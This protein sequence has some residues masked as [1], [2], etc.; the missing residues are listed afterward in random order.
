MHFQA[1]LGFWQNLIFVS[2]VLTS[3]VAT[4]QCLFSDHTGWCIASHV[5]PF[6]K[7]ESPSQASSVISPSVVY[8]QKVLNS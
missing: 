1:L 2:E 4:S 7:V 8:T 3:S 6:F 5:T